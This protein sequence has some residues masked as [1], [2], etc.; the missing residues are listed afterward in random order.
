MT[1]KRLVLL[2][3]VALIVL[4]L[5][6]LGGAAYV[7]ADE[8]TPPIPF[9]WGGGRFGGG[10]GWTGGGEWTA[11]DTAAETLGLTPEELFDELRAGN[12]LTDIAEEQGVDVEEVY[13]T[14]SAARSEAI[15]EAI[16]QAVDD[17]YLSQEQAD[18][19]LE[20]LDQNLFPMGRGFGRGRFGGGYPEGECPCGLH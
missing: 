15:P 6:G 1:K 13:E 14:I 12:S 18:W 20:G 9:G 8:P 3:G 10:F 7:F 11:Y 4:L 16:E 2:A 5:A 17:G 19:V